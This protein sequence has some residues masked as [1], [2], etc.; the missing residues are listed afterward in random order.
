MADSPPDMP[1]MPAMPAM[2]LCGPAAYAGCSS[3]R[4]ILEVNPALN[5]RMSI[6]DAGPHLEMRNNQDQAAITP[7]SVK[8]AALSQRDPFIIG[9]M[10]IGPI[11]IWHPPAPTASLA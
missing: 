3:V 8:A 11:S 7:A 10:M 2:S 1:A 4:I 6:L 5:V 9:R